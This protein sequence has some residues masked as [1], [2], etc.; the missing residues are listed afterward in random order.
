MQ[1]TILLNLV[2]VI[3]LASCSSFPAIRP[4]TD[5]TTTLTV[6][7][8]NFVDKTYY[9]GIIVITQYYTFLGNELHEKAYQLLS[10]SAQKPH[11]FEEYVTNARSAFNKVE[12]VTIQPLNVWK[13]QHGKSPIIEPDTLGKERFYVE[14]RAWGE[15]NMSGSRMNGDLQIIILTLVQKNDHWKINSFSQ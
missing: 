8:Q 3:V 12:I 2:L 10:A 13:K 4:E 6:E 11:S 15:G 9:D 7:P 14:I 5:L 1:L